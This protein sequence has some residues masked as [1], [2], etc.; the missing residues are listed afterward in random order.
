[1]TKAPILVTGAGGFVCS[2]IAAALI[3][4]GQAVVATD[5]VIDAATRDRLTGSQLIEAPIEVALDQIGEISAV[6]HGAALTADPKAL[7]ITAA[8]HLARN[9]GML[10]ASLAAARRAGAR[11]ALFL[12]SMGVF[13]ATDAPAR[14]GRF[15]EATLPTGRIPYAAAKQAGEI[16]TRAAADT[17]METLSVRL[18]NIAGPFE[19]VRESRQHLC[20][21]GRMIAEARSRGRITVSDP[22][23]RRE[24]AWLP[25]LAGG[26]AG[27][28]TAP[29][30]RASVLHAG[31]PPVVSHLELAQAIVARMPGVEVEV[32]TSKAEAI[33]PPMGS[34]FDGPLQDVCWTSPD[35]FLDLLLAEPVTA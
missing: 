11:R 35:D 18:G 15:T 22:D 7:G 5:R 12:S 4:A 20:L 26:I 24:W 27:L 16:V 1:M 29:W 13:S 8:E 10:T 32:S 33:R 19:A 6:I 25:D 23:G 21:V 28:M 17:Q 30:G 34:Q 9:V 31:T 2:E 14:E 3:S